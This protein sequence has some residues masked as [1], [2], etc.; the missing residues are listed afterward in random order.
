[1]RRGAVAIVGVAA[2]CLLLGG[3]GAEIRPLAAVRLDT[4]GAPR[5][6]LRPC[7]DDLI[8]G[9]SLVGAPAGRDS[10]RNRSGWQVRGKR[11]GSDVEFPLFSP[12]SA[13]RAR[14][15]GQQR[16]VPDYTYELG[17]GK[18]EFNYEYTG[19]VT[20]RAADL[21]TLKPGQVWADDRVM[22]LGEFERLAEDSC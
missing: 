11:H 10:G 16:L 5:A 9:L 3:C 12:P 19:T 4:E 1:M 13:W 7:G 6:V 15:A 17:F 2:G 8:Q 22:S 21:A 18:A 20:F 14:T